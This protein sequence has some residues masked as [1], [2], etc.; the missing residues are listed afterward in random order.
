M[1]QF[2]PPV[3]NR[4]PN[5]SGKMIECITDHTNHEG[6][7]EPV[8]VVAGNYQWTRPWDVLQTIDM[9]ACQHMNQEAVSFE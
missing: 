6:Q 7:V 8:N 9:H 2:L 1:E 4:E 3:G 5:S